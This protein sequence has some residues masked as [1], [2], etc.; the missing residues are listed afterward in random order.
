MSTGILFSGSFRNVKERMADTVRSPGARRRGHACAGSG[1]TRR[2]DAS[3]KCPNRIM[4]CALLAA[5]LVARDTETAAMYTDLRV[6]LDHFDYHATRRCVMPDGR[7]LGLRL[8][9]RHL[10]AGSIATFLRDSEIDGQALLAAAVRHARGEP[11]GL[12]PKI[13][14]RV[15]AEKQHH[16][17]LLHAFMDQHGLA[18]ATPRRRHDLLDSLIAGLMPSTELEARLTSLATADLIGKVYLRALE[19]ATGCRQL[20]ALCRMLVADQLAHVGFESD[21]LRALHAHRPALVRGP[22]ALALRAHFTSA[23]ISAWIEHRPVLETAGYSASTFIRACSA[24]WSFYLEP[25]PHDVMT[26]A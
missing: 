8:N 23:S 11:E 3:T 2:T 17:Q 10:I 20:R 5:T 6:W 9:E 13:V 21:L 16:V 26:A 1:R 4:E 14:G 15:V 18:P 22:L 7:R 19:A 12:L 24:Q 25:P